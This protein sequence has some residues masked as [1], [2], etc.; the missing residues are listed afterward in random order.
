M[1]TVQK[2]LADLLISKFKE[3][4][5]NT[6][7][8]GEIF[9]IQN[10]KS[11]YTIGM[12]RYVLSRLFHLGFLER[13]MNI[14]SEGY[15]LTDSGW[16]YESYNQVLSEELRKKEREE[17]QIQ[18]S[19]DSN[20]S[21]ISTNEIVQANLVTQKR[22]TRMSLW[23]AAISSVFI[24]ISTYYQY[25]DKTSIELNH[26]QKELNSISK[27]LNKI[28]GTLEGIRNSIGRNKTDSI[29]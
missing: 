20:K 28:K 27:E 23:L 24:I 25:Q 18:S 5:Y 4:E 15:H 12:I 19:I 3:H 16:Q 9:A 21:V 11:E 10:I 6:L 7:L 22:Q 13:A 2:E 17:A 14:T 8:I 1:T 29:P 26:L